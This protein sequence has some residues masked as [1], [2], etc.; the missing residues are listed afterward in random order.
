MICNPIEGTSIR[1]VVTRGGGY[2]IRCFGG[3]SGAP[4]A[5]RDV[6]CSDAAIAG[7]CVEPV[8]GAY[9]TGGQVAIQGITGDQRFDDSYSNACLVKFVNYIGVA[10]IQDLNAESAYGGGVIQHKFPDQSSGFGAGSPM[11]LIS[12][13]NCSVN[14]GGTFNQYNAG[15]DFLV[16][17]GG[18][19]TA[20]VTMQNI[21]LYAGNL[22]RDELTGRTVAPHDAYAGGL[23]Q[24]SCRVPTSY[25]ALSYGTY[26]RSRL[27]VGDKAIYTFTPPQTGWYRVMEGFA[28]HGVW[29]MGG[30]L[31]GE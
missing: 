26:V 2:G 11:G 24:G 4:A 22:I 30:K 12:I 28:T 1:N 10:S 20:S 27:V 13:M 18:E 23:S 19:R 21:N 15:P 14:L 7:L 16:L 8:P 29:R 25:E 6:V 17:K 9:Y 3:G 5:F 31:D